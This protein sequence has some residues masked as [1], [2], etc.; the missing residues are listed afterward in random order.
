[1]LTS[2]NTILAERG[3]DRVNL[4]LINSEGRSPDVC[5]G[6]M[7]NMILEESIH[8]GMVVSE[9]FL[10][11]RKLSFYNKSVSSL[12]TLDDAL[13][14]AMNRLLREAR[15]ADKQVPDSL[16]TY[17]AARTDWSSI[18]VDAEGGEEEQLITSDIDLEQINSMRSK[19]P[20]L[21]TGGQISMD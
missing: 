5:I 19:I 14:P 8:S 17:L 13:R 6:E 4:L 20:V 7:K 1:M 11:S 3:S 9:D 18:S 10:E 15:F 21:M 2:L 16:Y 12:V